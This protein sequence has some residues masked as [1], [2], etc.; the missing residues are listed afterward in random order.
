[1]TQE[2][3]L[4]FAQHAA[5][6]SRGLKARDTLTAGALTQGHCS[7][8]MWRALQQPGGRAAFVRWIVRLIT[9]GGEAGPAPGWD[10]LCVGP[11]AVKNLY[12]LFDMEV[13]AC[14]GGGRV[15]VEACL[16]YL[17][18]CPALPRPHH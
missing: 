8:A 16:C 1:M 5:G 18:V 12:Q 11:A 15:C 13:R 17:S 3:A 14:V 10:V 6:L 9:H 4:N 7:L 2:E